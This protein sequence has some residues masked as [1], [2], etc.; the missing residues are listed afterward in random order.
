M[1]TINI[2]HISIEMSITE[3]KFTNITVIMS[4]SVYHFAEDILTHHS[5]LGNEKIKLLIFN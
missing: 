3:A 1:V 2:F 5:E 4:F